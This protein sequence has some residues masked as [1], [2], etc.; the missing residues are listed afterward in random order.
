MTFGEDSSSKRV[1][2]AAQNFSLINKI[3]LNLIRKN[4]DGKVENERFKKWTSIKSRR[5]VAHFCDDY[6]LEL[7]NL[8]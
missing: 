2:F 7:L 8:I 3:V 4:K 6:L 1:G 5:R